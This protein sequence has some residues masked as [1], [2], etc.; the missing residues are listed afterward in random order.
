MNA[1]WKPAR[2]GNYGVG[3]AQKIS[4]ITFHHIVGDALAALDR[5]QNTDNEV[6]ST[7]VIGSDGTLYQCVKEGDT[8]YSDGNFDS[9]SRTISIEHAG[10][11]AGVPYTEAMYATSAQLVSSL[12]DKYGIKDFKRHSE[13]IDKTYYAGGTACPGRLDVERIINEAKE[14]IMFNEGDRVNLN[15]YCYGKDRG[16][17]KSLVGKDWKTAMYSFFKSGSEFDFEYKVN[18]GD[19]VNI[20][21]VLG[22]NTASQTRAQNWK[23]TFYSFVAHNLPSGTPQ[24]LKPGLYKVD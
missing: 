1:I 18:D 9:N 4:R 15:L 20:N 11:I 12:I 24:S 2:T 16:F 8:P 5:F 22:V 23:D 17:F 19:V 7:Y 10:G 3:R 21:N 6:S 14:M 13:V